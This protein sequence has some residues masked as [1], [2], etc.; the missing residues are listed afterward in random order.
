MSALYGSLQGNR[1]EATRQGTK[2]SGIRASV[3][4]WDG[5]L[6]AYMELDRETEEPVIRLYTTDD[7]SSTSYHANEMFRGSLKEFN[8][9]CE[10]YK[11]RKEA[12]SYEN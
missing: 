3:Q 10:D 1:G 5:S 8:K 2:G 11:K 12:E 9:M 6:I 4:S 7:S